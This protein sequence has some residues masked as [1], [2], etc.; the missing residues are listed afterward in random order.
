MAALA[1]A[2]S[3]L[4]ASGLLIVTFVPELASRLSNPTGSAIPSQS[5]ATSFVLLVVT[6][7][8][9]YRVSRIPGLGLWW[10][11]LALG[12]SAGV[13]VIKFILSP[14]AFAASR[15]TSL[16]E[17]IA[18]GLVVALAYV[19]ALWLIKRIARHRTYDKPW[20]WRSKLTLALGAALVAVA[21]RYLASVIVGAP[22]T[23]SIR[24]SFQEAGLILPATVLLAAASALGMFD[25]ARRGTADAAGEDAVATTI[26]VGT[27]LVVVYH[28]LWVLYMYRLFR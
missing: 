26:A 11:G 5:A 18:I 9:L 21:F 15:D 1:W 7:I 6:G 22:D 13:V 27:A 20:P 12:F 19:A 23:G 28:A 25:R 2:T 10:A 4:A 17:F 8:Y 3:A 14:S 24:H 16:G